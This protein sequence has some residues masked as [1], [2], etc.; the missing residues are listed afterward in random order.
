MLHAAFGV[1]DH[2]QMSTYSEIVRERLGNANV[3]KILAGTNSREQ[4]ALMLA[5]ARGHSN[6]IEEMVRHLR[7]RSRRLRR[8]I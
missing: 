2:P 8:Q 7:V 3:V 5:A 1:K 6:V 4:T